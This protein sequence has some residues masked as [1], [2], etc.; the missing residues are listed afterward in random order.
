M[1][2]VSRMFQLLVPI[3][4]YLFLAAAHAHGDTLYF[5]CE[6]GPGNG[7]IMTL[8]TTT[9]NLGTFASGF[10]NPYGLAFD[11][12]TNLYVVDSY[13][14]G[15]VL[16]VGPSGNW[17]VYKSFGSLSQPECVVVDGSGNLYVY[18]LAAGVRRLR[19]GSKDRSKQE[20]VGRRDK[21]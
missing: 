2:Q 15:S 3:V 9:G 6:G 8:D 5:S 21:Y 11:S 18:R 1:K 17:S 13:M 10:V 12:S 19:I 20:R 4:A 16:K 14:G 7:L